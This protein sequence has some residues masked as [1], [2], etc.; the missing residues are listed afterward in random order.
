[1]LPVFMLSVVILSVIVLIVVAPLQMR[2]KED[3]NVPFKNRK[4]EDE[5]LNF[6]D[7]I[8]FINFMRLE[9]KSSKFG[10]YQCL[11]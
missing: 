2:D 7:L 1:M 9:P 4:L 3:V 6:G 10:F 11:I 5:T 8:N